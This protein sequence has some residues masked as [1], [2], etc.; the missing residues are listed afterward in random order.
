MRFYDLQ[1]LTLFKNRKK[2]GI[3]EL[4]HKKIAQPLFLL[5]FQH[6]VQ[7][8]VQWASVHVKVC[9][10]INNNV[11]MTYTEVEGASLHIYSM[12]H[13]QQ[14]QRQQQQHLKDDL[15]LG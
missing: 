7:W 12:H 10:I 6:I 11:T 8:Q 14:Q 1:N 4:L 13:H 2:H 9:I 3:L 15:R 5:H